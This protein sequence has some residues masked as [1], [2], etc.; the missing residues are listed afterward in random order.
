M[1]RYPFFRTGWIVVLAALAAGLVYIPA[2][3]ARSQVVV[4]GR[5]AFR[6]DRNGNFGQ[7]HIWAMNPNGSNMSDL[8]AP[9]NGADPAWSG[10]STR[11]AYQTS[12]A[13]PSTSGFALATMNGDG[14]A[15]T[16]VINNS[17]GP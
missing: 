11:I 9:G 7:G 4:N 8:T 17:I 12:S 16:E 13:P 5:I 10:D 3:G 2:G 14:S 1:G 15:K 6:S